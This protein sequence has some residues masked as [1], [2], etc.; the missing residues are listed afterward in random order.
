M[1]R[2]IRYIIISAI[3]SATHLPGTAAAQQKGPYMPDISKA[4]T[5]EYSHETVVVPYRWTTESITKNL[6][7]ANFSYQ[8]KPDST[9]NGTTVWADF[10]IQTDIAPCIEP[11]EKF[12]TFVRFVTVDNVPGKLFRAKDDSGDE[13]GILSGGSLMKFTLN[14][15][16]RC[17]IMTFNTCKKW[18]PRFFPDFKLILENFKSYK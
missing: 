12:Y 5:I 18:V 15:N 7:R 1:K 16:K 9:C 11:E 4:Q 3:A 10:T 14:R 2:I 17:Y 13:T 8:K 6:I